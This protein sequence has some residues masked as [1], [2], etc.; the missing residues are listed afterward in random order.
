MSGRA[1]VLFPKEL[2]VLQWVEF[3][4]QG[5]DTPVPAII[6]HPGDPVECGVP[7]GAIGTGC[8][9]VITDGVHGFE[10][11]FNQW[12][13]WPQYETPLLGVSIA[14][15]DNVGY[16][17]G[18]IVDEDVRV[19]KELSADSAAWSKIAGTSE[20]GTLIARVMDA[21]KTPRSM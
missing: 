3:N 20:R 2:L 21:G 16:V 11:L 7:L 6:Y 13:R 17:L 9:D 14:G 8:L 4:A 10:L 1:N 12:P 19:G 5:F 15:E 18:V